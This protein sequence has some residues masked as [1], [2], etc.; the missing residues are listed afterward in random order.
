V[1]PDTK[2]FLQLQLMWVGIS[3]GI[4]I[5]ISLI[6]PFPFSIV[7]IIAVFLTINYYIRQRQMRKMGMSGGGFSSMFGQQRGVQYYC[8]NCGT[9]HN[10]TSCP[11]C[12]SKLKRAGFGD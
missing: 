2:K 8:I 6:V 9:R 10:Q 12:G 3:L 1:D 11:N 4:S 7:A 5:A